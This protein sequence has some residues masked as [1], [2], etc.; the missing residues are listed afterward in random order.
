MRKKIANVVEL[1]L[2]VGSFIIL[3]LANIQVVN[4]SVTTST[5]GHMKPFTLI[6]HY[7][8][9]YYILL[10]FYAVC[11]VMCII[12]IV[13]KSEHKDGIMHSIVPIL[14]CL[15]IHYSVISLGSQVGNWA[16]I[17]SNFPIA[18]F[19]VCVLG[20]V[21]IGFAKRSTLIAGFPK[22]VEVK[23]EFTKADE[24]KKFKDLLDSGAITQEEYDVKKKDLLS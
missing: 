16:I 13:T 12:S 22:T 20:V 6:A 11:A 2:L 24:L 19:E 3:N 14:W 4:L 17:E 1:I 18:A 10:F 21:I 9:V 7:P 23:Q 15:V 8:I 5:P